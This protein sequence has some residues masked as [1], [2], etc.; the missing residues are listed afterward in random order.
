[1]KTKIIL[2]LLVCGL[3]V[4]WVQS[5]PHSEQQAG[6]LQQSLLRQMAEDPYGLILPFYNGL[7]DEEAAFVCAALKEAAN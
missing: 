5:D 2:L 7:R 1:M 3:L 6:R 4:P